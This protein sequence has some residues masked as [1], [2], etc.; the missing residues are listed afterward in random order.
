MLSGI[1]LGMTEIVQVG[2]KV[3][4]EKAAEVPVTDITSEKIRSVIQRME[5][6]LLAEP[7]GAALAAPQL[8]IPLRIFVLSRRV[9][10][11]TS[12]HEAA[13]KDPHFVFINPVITKRSRKKELVDEGCLSVRGQYGT[14]KRHSNVTVTAYDEHGVRFSR[15]AGGL[16][17]Q[18][19]QHET[20]HLDGT[21]FID[22]AHE[23]WEVEVPRRD[24]R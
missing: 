7:D 1:V 9:F 23:I 15:G 11:E 24:A 21:L 3:L 13:S 10:G 5:E 12:E 18:A 2:H 17:A 6:A 22:H 8:G 16:L 20:D 4:R 14:V 19:F